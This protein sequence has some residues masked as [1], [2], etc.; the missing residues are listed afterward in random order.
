[1]ADDGNV[2]HRDAVRGREVAHEGI[3]IFNR[4]R[5]AGAVPARAG[6][7]AVTACVPGEHRI[8]AELQFIDDVLQAARVFVAAM[9]YH[10][11]FFLCAMLRRPMAV[12]QFNTIVRGKK[13][14][15][16]R[17]CQ[18]LFPDLWL[19]SA[20]R[21]RLKMVNSKSA[22]VMAHTVLMKGAI[23]I[24]HPKSNPVMLNTSARSLL[25]IG[26]A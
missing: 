26:P 3:D 20:A 17:A 21:P 9:E 15:F 8:A 2:F 11:R 13:S 23:Y 10:N 14:F 19:A 24:P 22:A 1:M 25:P 16:G 6:R 4:G 12:E 7:A 5:K 18:R